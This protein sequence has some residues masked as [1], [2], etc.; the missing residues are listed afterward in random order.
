MTEIQALRW[1]EIASA[2]ESLVLPIQQCATL[3]AELK[4]EAELERRF[5]R[6]TQVLL[7]LCMAELSALLLLGASPQC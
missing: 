4:H 3:L 7:W 2:V 6:W 5:A 1:R